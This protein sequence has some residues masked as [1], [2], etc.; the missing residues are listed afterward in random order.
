[1][2]LIIREILFFIPQFIFKFLLFLFRLYKQIAFFDEPVMEFIGGMQAVLLAYF[3][4]VIIV[5]RVMCFL[6][7]YHLY[8]TL[9]VITVLSSFIFYKSFDWH[10][11]KDVSGYLKFSQGIGND[12]IQK[13]PYLSGKVFNIP[14]PL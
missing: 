7:H 14:S 4:Q 10:N 8:M 1:L 12:V 6:I 11:L 2:G 13:F 3:P 9:D 5:Y